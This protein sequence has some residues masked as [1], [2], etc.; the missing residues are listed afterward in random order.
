MCTRALVARH[1]QL[2]YFSR[3]I[4]FLTEYSPY[5]R[6]LKSTF[7]SF[8][9]EYL[10]YGDISQTHQRLVK[11]A[12][13]PND[14][15]PNMFMRITQYRNSLAIR[16]NGDNESAKEGADDRLPQRGK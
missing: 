6:Q 7:A 2:V 11:L 16:T 3:L 14:Y 4:C 10:L 8:G 5:R 1:S 9:A 15:V 13:P 12:S